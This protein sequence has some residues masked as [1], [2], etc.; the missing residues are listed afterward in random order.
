MVFIKSKEDIPAFLKTA[1]KT[2]DLV[3]TLGA[4][5]IRKYGEM[6]YKMIQEK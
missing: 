2:G 4:G 6:F 1:V 3:I 5:D